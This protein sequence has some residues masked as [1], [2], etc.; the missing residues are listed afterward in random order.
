MKGKLLLHF[1]LLYP[2][3][4]TFAQKDQA[5][6]FTPIEEA[7]LLET[8]WKYTFA[9]H[10]ESNTIIHKAEKFL[11]IISYFQIQSFL[12]GICQWQGQR[13]IVDP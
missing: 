10:V 7:Q 12:S 1:L 8:K 3:R 2:A 4:T 13:R 6:E 9:L 11:R 5:C